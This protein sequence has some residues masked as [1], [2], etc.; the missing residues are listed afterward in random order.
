M[1]VCLW[2]FRISRKTSFSW[3]GQKYGKP[4]MTM[5]KGWHVACSQAISSGNVQAFIPPKQFMLWPDSCARHQPL[6]FSSKYILHATLHHHSQE[7]T[8]ESHQR[9]WMFAPLVW[10]C[11][12]KHFYFAF[13][14]TVAPLMMPLTLAHAYWTERAKWHRITFWTLIRIQPRLTPDKM[15]WP[16]QILLP[17]LAQLP[18]LLD[19]TFKIREGR[20]A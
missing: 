19:K 9:S 2:V 12:Y 3:N 17:E 4:I 6:C 16:G 10:L 1:L 18:T 15:S 14:I 20:E 5:L 7:Q 11:V 8:N 13:S